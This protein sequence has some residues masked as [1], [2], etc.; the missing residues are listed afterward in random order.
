MRKGKAGS[1]LRGR[2]S[3]PTS[4]PSSS[5]IEIGVVNLGYVQINWSSK[6][7]GEWDSSSWK[8]ESIKS[9]SEL[10]TIFSK[11][12]SFQEGEVSEI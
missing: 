5:G 11:E 2:K 6:S 4:E 3:Q 8:W 10:I 12:R 9:E 1:S 7:D